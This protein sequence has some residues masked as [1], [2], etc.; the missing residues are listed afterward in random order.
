M[1]KVRTNMDD[2]D[3]IQFK[4]LQQDA[5]NLLSTYIMHNHERNIGEQFHVRHVRWARLHRR[6]A[7]KLTRRLE[8]VMR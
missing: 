1:I 7:K 8:L 5:P 4:Y 3:W 6:I 2:T